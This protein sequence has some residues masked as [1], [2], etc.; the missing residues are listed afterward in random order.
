M[1]KAP[2]LLLYYQQNLRTPPI[3]LVAISC[4]FGEEAANGVAG[5]VITPVTMIAR[6]FSTNEI[7]GVLS[8]FC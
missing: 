3:S 7:L 5:I 4:K 8:V 2:S 6:C 1:P